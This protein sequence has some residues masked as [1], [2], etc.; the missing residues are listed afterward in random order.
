MREVQGE[1]RA[2]H[3]ALGASPAVASRK[4]VAGHV[5]THVG[6]ALVLLARGRRQGGAPGGLGQPATVLGRVVGAR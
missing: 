1:V 5:L 3:V 4:E 2:M 6:H